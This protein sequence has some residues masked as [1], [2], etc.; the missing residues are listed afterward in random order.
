MSELIP[1]Q[2]ILYYGIKKGY[3]NRYEKVDYFYSSSRNNS[4]EGAYSPRMSRQE[5]RGVLNSLTPKNIAGGI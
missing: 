2:C 1:G 3:N 5:R 4:G